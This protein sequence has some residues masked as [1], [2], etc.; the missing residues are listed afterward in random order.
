MGYVPAGRWKKFLY[1]RRPFRLRGAP[2]R[3]Y[4]ATA[5]GRNFTLAINPAR[6][7]GLISGVPAGTGPQLRQ[8]AQRAGDTFFE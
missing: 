2:K 3:R 5:A 8:C 4:G 7:A 6:R 1:F